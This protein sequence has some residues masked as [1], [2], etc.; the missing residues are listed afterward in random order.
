MRKVR[1]RQLKRKI[2]R[3]IRKIPTECYEKVVL[4][5]GFIREDLFL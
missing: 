3:F 4:R 1:S 2:L 5:S